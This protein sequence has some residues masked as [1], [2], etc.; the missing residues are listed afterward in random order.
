[1]KN[2]KKLTSIVAVVLLSVGMFSCS[3]DNNTAET[4]ALYENVID[5]NSTDGEGSKEVERE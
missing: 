5:T 4:D 3:E 2:L 1:M